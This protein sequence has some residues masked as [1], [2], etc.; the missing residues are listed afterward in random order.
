MYSNYK[1][2]YSSKSKPSISDILLR[3]NYINAYNNYIS[4]VE[5]ILSTQFDTNNSKNE[6]LQ[7]CAINKVI[8]TLSLDIQHDV[9]EHLINE[10]H[11]PSIFN[12]ILGANPVVCPKCGKLH[13]CKLTTKKFT[14]TL[15]PFDIALHPAISFPWNI[16]RLINTFATIGSTCNVPFSFDKSN[17]LSTLLEPINLLMITNG[18]HSSASGIYDTNAIYF[19]TE[20]C[21]ISV[22][23]KNIYFDGI[24]FRHKK[25]NAVLDYPK[26]KSIGIIYEIGRLLHERNLSL[27][28]LIDSNS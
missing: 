11:T 27:F 14:S 1:H 24:S 4:F 25:C 28:T 26:N 9:L 22:L 8:R 18:Y 16:S 15:I 17:H 20:Y 19:P 3:K 21:D 2:H 23:Y 12:S 13:D 6:F 7:L 5:N 10:Q